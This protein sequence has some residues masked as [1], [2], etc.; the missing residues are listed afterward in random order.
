MNIYSIIGGCRVPNFRLLMM[1]AISR[2][3]FFFGLLTISDLLSVLFSWTFGL[4]QSLWGLRPLGWFYY[5]H[6]S[7]LDF[8]AHLIF[9]WFPFLFPTLAHY[10]NLEHY[11]LLDCYWLLIFHFLFAPD[12]YLLHYFELFDPKHCWHHFVYHY[13][14]HHYLPFDWDFD[15]PLLYL[16]LCWKYSSI[17]TIYIST[18]QHIFW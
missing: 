11:W 8:W 10:L 16:H 9:P 13:F 7:G 15:F 5:Y 4:G 2:Y 6:H 1:D 12:L 14:E 3:F 17:S 18:S